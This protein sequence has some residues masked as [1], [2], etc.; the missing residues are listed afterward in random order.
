M[1]EGAAG[2]SPGHPRRDAAWPG[3]AGSPFDVVALVA[4]AGGLSA[5]NQV[6]LQLPADFGAAVVV[7]QHL[8]GSGSS[9]VDILRRRS[10]LPVDW[11]ADHDTLKPGGVLVCPPR[12]LLEVLPDGEC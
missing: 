6:L 3:S 12:H 2:E 4:S 5:L 10:P 9:L 7:V 1:T 8:G 11:I